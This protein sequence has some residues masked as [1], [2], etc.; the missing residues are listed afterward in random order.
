MRSVTTEKKIL[1]TQML[2]HIVLNTG[3]VSVSPRSDVYSRFPN[4]FVPPGGSLTCSIQKDRDG[5]RRFTIERDGI[6]QA[7]C[8]CARKNDHHSTTVWR[9]LCEE[10]NRKPGLAYTLPDILQPPWIAIWLGNLKSEESLEITPLILRQAWTWITAQ[11][12]AELQK[13]PGILQ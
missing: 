6:L 11:E 1:M 5:I 3:V 2:T 7:Q 8:W 12:E 10:R 4:S 13:G 9:E